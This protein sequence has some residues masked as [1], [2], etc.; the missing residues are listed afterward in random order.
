M[1]I[2]ENNIKRENLKNNDSNINNIN[3][4]PYDLTATINLNEIG[5]KTVEINTNINDLNFIN[6]NNY[7]NLNEEKT[8][9]ITQMYSLA[10]ATGDTYYSDGMKYNREFGFYTDD[11]KPC[12]LNNFKTMDDIFKTQWVKASKNEYTISEAEKKFNI[13]IINDNLKNNNENQKNNEEANKI[14]SK[15]FYDFSW[16]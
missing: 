11:M 8:L 1:D 12:S 6:A 15:T 7:I 5:S 2:K 3:N 4:S 9:N 10:N 13:K 16:F 14:N